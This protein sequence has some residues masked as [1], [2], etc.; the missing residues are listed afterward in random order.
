M[1]FREFTQRALDADPLFQTAQ[2]QAELA[3]YQLSAVKSHFHPK[4]V[5]YFSVS[6]PDA[7]SF[8]EDLGA[9]IRWDT[10]WGVTM[11][12]TA[13]TYRIEYDDPS[14]YQR[15]DNYNI[16]MSMP[17]GKRFGRLPAKVQLESARNSAA[18]MNRA[19][20]DMKRQA[21]LTIVTNYYGY[22]QVQAEGGVSRGSLERAS[23]NLELAEVKYRLGEASRLDLD[24][25]VYSV[26]QAELSVMNHEN[27]RVRLRQMIR[28]TYGI[29]VEGTVCFVL[30]DLNKIE[31]PW[32]AEEADRKILESDPDIL[33]ARDQVHLA[34][35]QYKLA[36]R[37]IWPSFDFSYKL[38]TRNE[39][40]SGKDN[41]DD[42]QEIGLNSDLNLDFADKRLIVHAAG[43][44]LAMTRINLA[45]ILARETGRITADYDNFN[46]QK[47]LIALSEKSL[48]TAR[49]QVAVAELRFER[50][51][52]SA[53]DVID[54]QAQ[55]N[56][57][58]LQHINAQIEYILSYYEILYRVQIL[59][60]DWLVE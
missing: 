25:A 20:G 48:E 36:K 17:I 1:G 54:S 58:E 59:D 43:S 14:E 5:P 30:P 31:L 3:P 41:F 12:A 13:E 24:R 21:I 16:R 15:T 28:S 51:I 27:S 55:L 57:A 60:L 50:G 44:Q 2:I 46:R 18:R 7:E 32:S 11:D 53:F 8:R 35:L 10:G 52:G 34:E 19:A 40:D 26:Q 56:Q 42:Y 47:K 22:L 23:K 38:G 9:G 6:R 33:D 39:K 29:D 4:L 37:E 45:R 49:N